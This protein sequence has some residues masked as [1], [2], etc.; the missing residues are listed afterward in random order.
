MDEEEIETPME[1]EG[2]QR[3]MY[4]E[5]RVA[6]PFYYRGWAIV[7]LAIISIKLP[8]L[9]V[10]VIYLIIMRNL[11]IIDYFDALEVSL[12]ESFREAYD[13]YVDSMEK[14]EEAKRNVVE[15]SNR[16]IAEAECGIWLRKQIWEAQ[17][18][19]KEEAADSWRALTKQLNE[20]YGVDWH[21]K[22]L[23]TEKE[24]KTL[25][26]EKEALELAVKQLRETREHLKTAYA[27]E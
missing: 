17:R 12:D 7:T 15:D 26:E 16:L 8:L 13:S 4:E 27:E 3:R 2:T 21:E 19:G 1:E 9:W 25:R 10:A 11:R 20:E 23:Q 6:I 22:A 14:V 5:Y 24:V 18:A